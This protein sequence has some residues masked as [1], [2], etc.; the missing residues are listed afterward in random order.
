MTEQKT[1]VRFAPSPTGYL[2]IGS[3]RTALFNWL[4]AKASKGVFLLRIEDTDRERS[5]KKYVDEIIGSLAWLG[6]S[7]ED[8]PVYQTKR[9]KLYRQF[10]SRLVEDGAAYAVK[11]GALAFRMPK[12]K[13]IV[14]DLIRG[15]IEFDGSLQE[16]LVIIKSDGNPTYNFAC[17]VDDIDMGITHVIRGDDHISNTPKQIALYQALGLPIPLF[18]HIPL[19]LGEDRSRLSKRHGATSISEYRELGYLPEAMVNFM[20]LLGW[21][22]GD[23]REIMTLE[24]L[25]AAFSLERVVKTA[26]VFNLEKLNWINNQYIKNMDTGVLAGLVRGHMKKCGVRKKV[27]ATELRN[28]VRL[29]K[30]RMNRI[31]DFCPQAR[32]FFTQDVEFEKDAADNLM[33]RRE[34]KIIFNLLITGLGR[35][36]PFSPEAIEKCCRDIIQKLGISSGDLIHPVRAAITGRTSSP[37]LFEVMHLLGKDRTIKRLKQALVKFCK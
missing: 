1:R 21:S 13:I 25:V 31:S 8:R 28:M 5:H 29:F 35:V 36:R 18:A 24:E 32:Y 17:V 37:G 12:E 27:G 30:T 34:L 7:W 10:A 3:A 20:A 23:N 15:P 33:R 2:H 6:I 22:P 4:F 16:D 11:G 14:S 26:A 9:L 19:I